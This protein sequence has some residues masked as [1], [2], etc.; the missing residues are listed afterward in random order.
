MALPNT[1]LSPPP[2]QYDFTW[3]YYLWEK[4]IGRRTYTATI[5]VASV[6]ANTTSEQTFT[7]S[8]LTT[9]DLVIVNKPSHDAGLGIVGQRVSGT[10]TI[11]ITYMNTT[12]AAIDPASET[13]DIIAI[14]R[15]LI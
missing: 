10:D 2:E 9:D 1:N 7:V 11:A 5:D 3:I 12:A 14:K 4:V 8:G 15:D 6:A 13:Y